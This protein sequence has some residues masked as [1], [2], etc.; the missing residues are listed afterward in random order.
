MNQDRLH[1]SMDSMKNVRQST[2]MLQYGKH[3]VR[4]LTSWPWQLLSME[5]C[6]VYMVGL[7]QK[8]GP[9]IKLG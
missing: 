5:R 7:A 8:F 3:V 2:V 4:Y 1:K 6:S 9:L